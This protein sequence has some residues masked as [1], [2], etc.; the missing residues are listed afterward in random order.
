[1][2]IIPIDEYTVKIIKENEKYIDIYK[3]KEMYHDE[4]CYGSIYLDYG[5][6]WRLVELSR[7]TKNTNQTFKVECSPEIFSPGYND[8][9]L[10][11]EHNN[12][13]YERNL[14]I[15][16]VNATD[17]VTHDLISI[18]EETEIPEKYQKNGL[19]SK[20]RFRSFIENTTMLFCGTTDDGTISIDY[21]N[22]ICYSS[23]ILEKIQVNY[24]PLGTY[25]MDNE[26]D[27]Y[28][29]PFKTNE[30]FQEFYR[31]SKE[32]VIFGE[33]K[34]KPKIYKQTD[35][36]KKFVKVKKNK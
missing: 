36:P 17:Y 1:M 16:Q 14:S 3:Y 18:K 25:I 2:E 24:V 20:S 8:Y 15:S 6:G 12:I 26:T 19:K 35:S 10:E 33:P 22:D 32:L 34:E 9:K 27:S 28:F 11:F 29:L 30:L 13:H 4:F 7:T 23:K 5:K 21:D 31:M